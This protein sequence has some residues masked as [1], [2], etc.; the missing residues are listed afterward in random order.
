[1]HG[2]IGGWTLLTSG[3][4][5]TGGWCTVHGLI[6]SQRLFTGSGYTMHWLMDGW[7]S[8]HVIKNN[9]GLIASR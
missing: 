7:C 1:M 8:L 5:F 3:H 6:S 9:V 4:L 2:L